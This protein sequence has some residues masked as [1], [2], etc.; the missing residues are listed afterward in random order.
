[1]MT[2]KDFVLLAKYLNDARCV[3]LNRDTVMTVAITYDANSARL[4]FD[5]AL[6]A[7][8]NACAASN[9]RFDYERFKE[10]VGQ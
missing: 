4:G 6:K 1:M 8:E 7:V 2:R 9:P 3:L 5:E 10:A